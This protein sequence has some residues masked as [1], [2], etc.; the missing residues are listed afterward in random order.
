MRRDARSR[1]AK[2]C[3]QKIW[4]SEVYKGTTRNPLTSKRT[5]IVTRNNVLS[6]RLAAALDERL[7]FNLGRGAWVDRLH[8][9][10]QFGKLP[11]DRTNWP[12]KY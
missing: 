10:K 6:I 2:E 7:F 9:R 5:K 1:V 8:A 11:T 4:S 12:P 3:N